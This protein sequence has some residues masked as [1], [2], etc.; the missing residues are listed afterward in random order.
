[1]Q[2]DDF[3]FDLPESNI[4]LEPHPTRDGSKLLRVLPDGAL[5]DHVFKNLL[6]FFKPGDVVVLNNSRVLPAALK[7]KRLRG[8]SEANVQLNLHK[9]VSSNE[10]F[11]FAKPA[12]R[13]KV[14]DRLRFGDLAGS[15]QACFEGR[16]EA[17]IVE[18]PGGGEIL[19]R[20]DL[21][22][23]ALDE[24]LKLVGD[25][26]LPPYIAS[27]RAAG[28]EDKETYQTVYAEHDGSVAAPTAGLHFTDELLAGLKEIG[29]DLQFVTLHVGAGTFLPVKVD[30]IKSHKMHAEWGQVSA[31]T[32]EAIRSAKLAGK[33][34]CAVGTTS[35]RL[36]ESAALET[37]E[38]EPW[39]G[40]TDIFI[41]P[42]F[43]FKVVDRLITNFHLP[44]STL[45]MLVSAFS[46]LDVMQSAYKAAIERDYR[47]YSYGDG[48]LLE[49]AHNG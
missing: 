42:G 30:D 40:E 33:R 49:G 38:I 14:G 46:G 43:Q 16:L 9:R 23:V 13:M 18:T 32:V 4:A 24:A 17:T 47:F 31:E 19:V 10:W 45:F 7:G 44:K 25:M 35:L 21:D 37:G 26:P 12:K 28:E 27:K 6:R 8:E 11:A 5:E 39:T 41:T 34:V 3:D 2:L 36:L 15:S 1:M 48:C 20:F 29:V 22:G